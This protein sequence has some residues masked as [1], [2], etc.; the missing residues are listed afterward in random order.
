M[1]TQLDGTVTGP[2]IGEPRVDQVGAGIPTI[3]LRG[4]DNAA[5][6]WKWR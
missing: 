3:Q 4:L 6:E 1:K 2:H 5:C